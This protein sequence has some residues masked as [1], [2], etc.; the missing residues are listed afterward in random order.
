M[1]NPYWEK[2][3]V[4][5]GVYWVGYWTRYKFFR[6]KNHTKSGS[7][8][9]VELKKEIVSQV[10]TPVDSETVHQLKKPLEEIGPIYTARWRPKKQ[11][12]GITIGYAKDSVSLEPYLEDKTFKEESYY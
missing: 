8:K 3:T 6:V 2:D 12:W 7:P 9:V 4:L 11:N 10:S 5:L 1:E